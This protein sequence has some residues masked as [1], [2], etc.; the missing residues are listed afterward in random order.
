[1]QIVRTS[2]NDDPSSA[3]GIAALRELIAGTLASDERLQHV[4]DRIP[5]SWLRIKEAI[6]KRARDASVLPLKEFEQLCERTSASDDDGADAIAD[7]DEQRALLRLL[8]DLGVVVAHGLERDAP[9]ALREI[10]SSSAS[11]S[12]SLVPRSA[13]VQR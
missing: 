11:T 5:R 3:A 7:P 9:A 1:M 13:S 6:A 8:H 12:P 2:C 4:R 10:S